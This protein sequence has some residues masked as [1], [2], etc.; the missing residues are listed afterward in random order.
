MINEN[1]KKSITSIKELGKDRIS[2]FYD[3]YHYFIDNNSIF[4]EIYHK[5]I[6]K[7]IKPL[8]TDNINNKIVIQKTP[9]IRISF[10]NL[11]AIGKKPNE[12][13]EDNIIGLHK[14]ADFGHHE[15]EINVIIPITKMF[16]TNSIFYEPFINS[17]ISTNDYLNLNLNTD[18]FFINK[19]NKL[20]HFNKINK[21]GLTRISLD[22]RIIPYNKYFNNLLFFKNTKFELGNYYIVL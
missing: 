7:Y 8:Y 11:T 13:I 2:I 1:E 17:N 21:T 9:N 19:F 6:N 18:E 12:N 14:D 20:L 10:P 15:D 4:N 5:F 16:E 3:D 22:F